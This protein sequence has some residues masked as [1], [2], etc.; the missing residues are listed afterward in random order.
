MADAKATLRCQVEDRQV[1]TKERAEELEWTK[2]ED[3]ERHLSIF[4]KHLDSTKKSR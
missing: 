1:R 4:E 2:E 3:L